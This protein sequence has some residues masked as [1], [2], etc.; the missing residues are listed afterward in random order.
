MDAVHAARKQGIQQDEDWPF[1]LAMLERLEK[2]WRE[3]DEGIWEVRGGARHFT[4]SRM[5]CWV[6]FD[7]G[8]RAVEDYGCEGPVARWRRIREDIARDIHRHGWNERKQ[9]FVQSYGKDTLDASLLLMA[10]VGFLP[11]RDA[12]YVA[13]VAAI[14]R[15]LLVDGLVRRY[16]PERADDGLPG[17]E[18]LFLACSFWLADAYVLL[19]RHDDAVALFERLLT[20]RNDLGLLAEEYDVHGRRQLGNFPQAFSHIALINTANN[21]VSAFGPAEQRADGDGK[22]RA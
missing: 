3:P 16:Q 13:T 14:E 10:Q 22:T 15:E 12:R 4:F 6:A 20:L 1:Q 7:R 18:G 2:S 17:S 21:L 11:A 19:G 9:A 5:M 8:I